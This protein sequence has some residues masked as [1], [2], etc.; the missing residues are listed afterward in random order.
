MG[1]R[2]AWSVTQWDPAIHHVF[3]DK[4]DARV[5]FTAGP[6][7]GWTRLPAH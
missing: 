1:P 7:N 6:A 5:E 4:T 2:E 3:S